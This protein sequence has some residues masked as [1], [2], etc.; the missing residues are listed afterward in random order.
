M[1]DYLGQIPDPE[2]NASG[3]SG[4]PHRYSRVPGDEYDIDIFIWL[5]YKEYKDHSVSPYEIFVNNSSKETTI[6]INFVKIISS[7]APPDWVPIPPPQKTPAPLYVTPLMYTILPQNSPY[8]AT[9]KP[10]QTQSVSLGNYSNEPICKYNYPSF[11]ATFSVNIS[12]YY[13]I[14]TYPTYVSYT[15]PQFW[16]R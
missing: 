5:S 2:E 15:I 7:S 1:P 14:N 8:L 12:V 9:V 4:E 13:M 10:G 11:Y 16:L 6:N 3:G